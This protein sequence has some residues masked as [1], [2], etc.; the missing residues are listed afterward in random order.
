ML[1]NVRNSPRVAGILCASEYSSAENSQPPGAKKA[2]ETSQL[3]L[4]RRQ[5]L[6]YHWQGAHIFICLN[7]GPGDV[8]VRKIV[9]IGLGY[10]AGAHI[11]KSLRLVEV[12]QLEIQTCNCCANPCAIH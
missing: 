4:H 2:Y 6:E 10:G 5:R 9:H 1:P 12:C 8:A 7:V 11:A 3:D